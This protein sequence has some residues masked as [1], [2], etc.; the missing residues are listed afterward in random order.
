MS[1]VFVYGAEADPS[2]AAAIGMIPCSHLADLL[3][4]T[5]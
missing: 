4:K 3:N 1:I 2:A 5:M